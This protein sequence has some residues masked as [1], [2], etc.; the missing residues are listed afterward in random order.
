MKA[1][2]ILEASKRKS[3]Y[4]E[5]SRARAYAAFTLVPI[6]TLASLYRRR[7]EMS[8]CNARPHWQ[9]QGDAVC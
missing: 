9:P 2:G 6:A 7:R 4:A 3:W 5:C 1:S 8:L